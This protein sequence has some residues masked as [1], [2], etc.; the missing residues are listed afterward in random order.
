MAGVRM[1]GLR[2]K[3]G[4]GEGKNACDLIKCRIYLGQREFNSFHG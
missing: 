4:M 1:D 3:E 2:G